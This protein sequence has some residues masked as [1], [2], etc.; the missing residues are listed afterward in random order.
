MSDF[1]FLQRASLGV[2]E[3]RDS[4]LHKRDPR[5]MLV[6]TILFIGTVIFSQS[7]TGLILAWVIVFGLSFIAKIPF[8]Q[9]MKILWRPLPFI[10]ILAVL[11]L[12]LLKSP[13]QENIF[14]QICFLSATPTGL[15]G[16][17]RLLLRF[18]A[19]ILGFSLVS[20]CVPSK[21]LVQGLELLLRP[22]T[23]W[24][25]PVYDMV[26]IFQVTLRFIPLLART[27]ERTAK[28]QAAR[29]ADW[30]TKKQGLVQKVKQIIPL[31]IPLFMSG[32]NKA[33]NLALAMDA[34]GYGSSIQ[35]TSA[36]KRALT[37]ED[38]VLLVGCLILCVLVA[39][40]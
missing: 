22:L 11:Q 13:G 5:V 23:K 4:W 12:F 14:F 32:L 34:R 40:L 1:D 21:E 31:I 33:E 2:Y 37:E 27:A 24:K 9:V 19:L 25:I 36:L 26:L 15:L 35:R 30:G 38:I 10:L 28:A 39:I 17:L 20:F 3:Y 7:I 8:H 29:G 16:A 18:L 6:S